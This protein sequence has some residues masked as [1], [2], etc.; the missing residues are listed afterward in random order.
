MSGVR[1]PEAK[2]SGQRYCVLEGRQ[3]GVCVIVGLCECVH[4]CA[5]PCVCL[6]VCLRVS[7]CVGYECVRLCAGVSV[8]MVVRVCLCARVCTCV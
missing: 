6:C 1:Y 8:Y 5:H 2:A 7:A 3:G 4:E